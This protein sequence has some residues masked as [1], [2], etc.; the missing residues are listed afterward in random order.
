LRT[1]ERGAAGLG[2]PEG[3]GDIICGDEASKYRSFL[4]V[5]QP[6]EHGIVKNWEDMMEIWNYTFFDKLK[7]DTRGRKI[8]LTE[9][10]MNPLKNRERMVQI[11]IESYGFQGVFVAIQAVLT[12]Y[13]QGLQ[14]GVVVDSGDG[15]THIVPVYDGFALP[16][17]TKRLDVLVETLRD[18]SSS[19][20]CFADTL[21]TEQQTLRRLDR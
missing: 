8:L 2:L 17:T 15:V 14:T 6:M 9:P 5:S 20:Y 1:E 16:H 19:F 7:T 3:L 13:A 4:Q 12:L 11:M 10:P 21:S 18:T